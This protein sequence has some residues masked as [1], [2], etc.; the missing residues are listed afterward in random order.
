M[1]ILIC[2]ILLADPVISIGVKSGIII[3]TNNMEIT[4]KAGTFIP[5]PHDKILAKKIEGKNSEIKILKTKLDTIEKKRELD[6]VHFESKEKEQQKYWNGRWKGAQVE[7][8]YLK[9]PWNR[10]GKIIMWCV[11]SAA[12]AAGITYLVMEIK[13]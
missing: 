4:I 8:A 3:D 6:A 5:D 7:I 1:N 2:I 12:G 13:N 9:S 11:I 10:Y